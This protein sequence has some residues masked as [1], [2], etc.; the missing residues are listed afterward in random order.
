VRSVSSHFAFPLSLFPL[1]TL[2]PRLK[3]RFTLYPCIVRTFV[4]RCLY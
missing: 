3:A 4:L 2:E 1:L